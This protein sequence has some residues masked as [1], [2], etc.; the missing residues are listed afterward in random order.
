M[1]VGLDLPTQPDAIERLCGLQEQYK[2]S[3]KL[4]L[5]RSGPRF[6]HPSQQLRCHFDQL[7]PPD[8]IRNIHDNSRTLDC[9]DRGGQ[10]ELLP[11]QSRPKLLNQLKIEFLI[12]LRRFPK[13]CDQMAQ[14]RVKRHRYVLAQIRSKTVSHDQH[15]V[16]I[17][18]VLAQEVRRISSNDGQI[19]CGPPVLPEGL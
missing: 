7:F 11:N 3:F 12:P 2:K 6:F 15:S 5:F 19:Q 10:S 18:A 16:G 1:L 14:S 8:P 4:R 17:P 9:R 13:T